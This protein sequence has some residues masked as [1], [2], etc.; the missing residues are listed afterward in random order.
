[1]RKKEKYNIKLSYG[2]TGTGD[3][4]KVENIEYFANVDLKGKKCLLVTGDGGI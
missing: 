1:M 4:L 2:K 3:L